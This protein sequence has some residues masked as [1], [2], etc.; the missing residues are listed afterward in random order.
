MDGDVDRR[1]AYASW[2]QRRRPGWFN[3][4]QAFEALETESAFDL[5]TDDGE[6]KAALGAVSGEMEA[7]ETINCLK[8]RTVIDPK[9]PFLSTM[10]LSPGDLRDN[11]ALLDFG[12]CPEFIVGIARYMGCLPIL[13]YVEIWI[14][15]ATN[16]DIASSQF[17]HCDADDQRISS[18]FLYASDVDEKSRPVTAIRG[19]ASARICAGLKYRYGGKGYR[20]ADADRFMD[21]CS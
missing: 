10:M 12:I 4:V 8:A 19:A 5:V 9:K 1:R 14:S 13:L 16:D 20:V 15:T 11:P 7:V 2:L 21:T 17:V 6:T 3:R 18:L